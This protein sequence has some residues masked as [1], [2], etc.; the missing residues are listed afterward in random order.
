MSSNESV[1]SYLKSIDSVRQKCTLLLSNPSKLTAFDLNLDSLPKVTDLVVD[2][3]QRD[4]ATPADIPPHTRGR[5]FDSSRLKS[6]LESWQN[7]DEI[8][9]VRRLVDLYLVSARIL[10]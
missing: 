5:H 7:V 8:E 4:Y 3:I 2:S 1:I 10:N 9:I 6:L